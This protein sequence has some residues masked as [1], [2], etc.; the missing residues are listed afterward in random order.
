MFQ[1]I[2]DLL[3]KEEKK[4]DYFRRNSGKKIMATTT[5][6][7]EKEHSGNAHLLNPDFVKRK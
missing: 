4:E 3:E 6:E 2:K 7:N 5:L 1:K